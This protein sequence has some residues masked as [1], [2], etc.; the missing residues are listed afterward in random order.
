MERESHRHESFGQISFSR[1]CGRGVNF[2]GSELPQ[3]NY[4]TMEVKYSEINREL[5][6]DRYYAFGVPIIK[7][8][9]SSGQFAEMITSMNQGSGVPCT[10]ERLSGQKVQDLPIQE[11]RKEFVHRKFDDRMKEF[12]DKIRANQKN[13]KE[14]VKKKTLSKQDIF[15]LTYQLEWLT[16]EVESNIPFFAKCFQETMDEV[17]YE[18]KLEVENA[19]QHK[20]STLG[21]TALQEQNKLLENNQQ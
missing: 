8:R 12:A 11:S 9:L 2:Y 17:V 7:I 14:I 10:I 6:Q 16:T 4:I 20:I 13:A 19:I 21:L 5:T 15:D 3:D 18:A 1:V